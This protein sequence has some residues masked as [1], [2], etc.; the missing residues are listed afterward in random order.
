MVDF[1]E[2][3]LRK[4][5]LEN[6]PFCIQKCKVVDNLDDENYA[7]SSLNCFEKCLGKF[8]DSYEI[9]LDIFG[10]HLTTLNQKQVFTHANKKDM[11]ARFLMGEGGMDPVYDRPLIRKQKGDDDLDD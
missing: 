11:E 7:K 10:K 1:L 4:I 3:N 8:S 6:S 9:G 5:A 2:F